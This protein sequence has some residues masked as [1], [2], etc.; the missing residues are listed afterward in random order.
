MHEQWTHV[1][2]LFTRKKK[3]KKKKK[4]TQTWGNAQ[5]KRSLSVCLNL[6][7]RFEPTF[8]THVC[9]LRFFFFFSHVLEKR[10]YYSCTV[11]W[12]VTANVDFFA[13]NNAS[14]YCL[15][16]HKFHF[17]ATFL[18]KIGPI[19]LFTHLKIILLECFQFSVFSFS[20][21]SFIQTNP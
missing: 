10:G 6:R 18:L 21:I 11:Y 12:T 20:K 7:L 15:W 5:C 16:T 14:V 19:A 13:V 1:R 3:K 4:K 17:S 9:V 2:L 8:W